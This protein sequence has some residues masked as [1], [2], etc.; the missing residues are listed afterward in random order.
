MNNSIKDPDFD[1]WRKRTRRGLPELAMRV[2]ALRDQP[3]MGS[4]FH[5]TME[6]E[7]GWCISRL[8]DLTYSLVE[9]DMTDFADRKEFRRR[10][11][12]TRIVMQVRVRMLYERV[13]KAE[14]SLK[15]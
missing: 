12:A 4:G 11:V 3:Y 6:M 1:K 10:V 9:Y 2:F 7:L 5:Y 13:V 15:E 8:S 14:R